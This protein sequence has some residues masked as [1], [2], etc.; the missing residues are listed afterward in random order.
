MGVLSVYPGRFFG[1]FFPF[2]RNFLLM[3]AG[4]SLR[5]GRGRCGRVVKFS[6]SWE[7]GPLRFAPCE[8][9]CGL[10]GRL[11]RQRRDICSLVNLVNI[12]ILIKI[13]SIIVKYSVCLFGIFIYS[14]YSVFSVYP[15]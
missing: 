11:P 1:V 6:V 13:T 7:L 10:P 15:V 5:E 2:V 4:H 9:M 3:G 14:V 8:A 12:I